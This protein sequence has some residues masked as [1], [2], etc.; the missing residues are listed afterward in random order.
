[1]GWV[2]KLGEGGLGDLE[3]SRSRTN[4][5]PRGVDTTLPL[6][7]LLM[8]LL[9]LPPPTVR[10]EEAC[11]H[12]FFFMMHDAETERTIYLLVTTDCQL[13][14]LHLHLSLAFA[15]VSRHILTSFSPPFAHGRSMLY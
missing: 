15:V 8:L 3:G 4:R 10:G 1:M 11:M 7:L 2:E 5:R 13:P 9:V 12:D 6:L 14:P